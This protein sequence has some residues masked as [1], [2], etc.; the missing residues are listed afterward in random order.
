MNKFFKKNSEGMWLCGKVCSC[1][2]V[3]NAVVSR[4]EWGKRACAGRAGVFAICRV[5]NGAAV[6]SD[7]Q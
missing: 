4:G 7:L 6:S 5:Y 2:S 3:D 1:V